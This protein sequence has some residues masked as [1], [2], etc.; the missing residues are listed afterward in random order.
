MTD[1]WRLSTIL[2]VLA[3]GMFDANP[4]YADER[5]LAEEFFETKIRP[6]LVER[7]IECH[8]P[9]EQWAGLRLDTRDALLKGGESGAAIVPGKPETS[10]LL[11]RVRE[12]DDDLRMPPA[13]SGDRLTAPQINAL[14]QWIA[15]GAVWPV[16]PTATDESAVDSRDHWAFQPVRSF[17][18]P[19]IADPSL[20]QTPIDRVLLN[21]LES[22]DLS[23]APPADRRTLIRRLTYDLTG[24]PIPDGSKGLDRWGSGTAMDRQSQVV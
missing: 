15:A 5:E 18:P 11:H 9:G 17:T 14:Q 10:Q 23:F 13:E 3:G 22:V 24:L 16:S 20:C 7:C 21:R 8:G 12:P 1:C 2:I 4:V 19:A 6:L